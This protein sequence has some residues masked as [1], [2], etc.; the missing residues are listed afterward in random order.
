[1]RFRTT[2]SAQERLAGLQAILF[3]LD[4]TLIDTVELIRVSFRYA[5]RTVLGHELPDEVTM[6]NVGQPL[7]QQF[8]DMAPDHADELLCVYREYNMARH[9]ELAKEY[10]GTAE[11]LEEIARRRIPM[12][13]VT[14]KGAQATDRGLDLFDLH[15][16]MR[17]V[18]TADDVP[19]HKPDPYPLAFAAGLL[20]A[21]LEYCIYVG[22][23]PHDMQAAVSGG[24]VSVAALWGAFGVRDVLAPGPDYSLERIG[25]LIALL[26]GCAVEYAVDRSAGASKAPER[27]ME[28]LR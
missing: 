22:D 5:T 15:R 10:P 20:G 13:V 26:D 28:D 12:G 7:A 6:A 19:V 8:R 18:I 21:E 24:A 11:T 4:G 27:R 17:V 9:D 16:F 25:D 3:D 23:S 1:M 14:S 2:P